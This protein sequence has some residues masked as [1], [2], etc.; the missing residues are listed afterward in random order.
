[1]INPL[2]GLQLRNCC[3]LII[4]L[5]Y[6]DTYKKDKNGYIPKV[7]KHVSVSCGVSLKTVKKILKDYNKIPLYIK[8]K[9]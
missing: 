2:P 4:C 5:K 7:Q 9:I 1:M 8:Q 6:T 3:T